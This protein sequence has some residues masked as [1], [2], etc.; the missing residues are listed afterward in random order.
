MLRWMV[1]LLLLANAV[2]FAW[3]QGH[4]AALGFAPT[5]QSEPERLQGQIKPEALRLLNGPDLAVTPAAPVKPATATT[6]RTDPVE[7]APHA[8]QTVV[9][10]PTACWQASGF[11]D[12]QA[13]ALKRELTRLGLPGDR[14]SLS[15]IRTGGR[16][17]VYMGRYNDDLLQRKKEE[18]RQ[19]KVE[20]RTLTAPPLGNGL[21]LG[22]YSTEDA[23]EQGL[24]DVVRKGVRSAR[25]AQ[26]R[27]P[28]SSY[29]L[30]LPAITPD[31]HAVLKTLGSALAGKSLQPCGD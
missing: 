4:L 2:Y 24:K 11:N 28:S 15:E 12:A 8:A 29:T 20:F 22:T 1:G 5:E 6:G 7:P 26:E 23:A 14:W 21:A 10:T 3:T 18:L 13:T 31:E 16:W 30:R 9:E 17:V 25:V 27:D 19:L